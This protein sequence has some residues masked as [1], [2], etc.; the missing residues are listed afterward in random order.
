MTH[1][2]LRR[3][4]CVIIA[5]GLALLIS[6]Q[7]ESR[8]Q[9]SSTVPAS[10]DAA[11][12]LLV[13]NYF[14][15]LARNDID[16]FLKLWSHSAEGLEQR[17]QMMQRTSATQSTLRPIFSNFTIL[18]I[19]IE[20]NRAMLRIEAKR[21]LSA[22]A[23][24]SATQVSLVLECVKEDGEWRIKREASAL[25]EL[26]A[27][28]SKVKT[29]A[30]GKALLDEEKDLI[31]PVLQDLIL[32]QV[33]RAF[34]EQNHSQALLLGRIAKLIAEQRGDKKAVADAWSS[35]GIASYLT[36]KYPAALEAYQQNLKLE[37]E[38]GDQKQVASALINIGH[39]YLV[40][41]Q[42]NSALEYYQKGLSLREA[43]GEK[44]EIANAL[45]NVANAQYEQGHYNLAVE[46]YQKSIG[47][48][49]EAKDKLRIAVTQDRI[50][51]LLYDQGDYATALDY[52]QQALT[53]F[54]FL[55]EKQSTVRA[56]HNI[57]N[58]HYLQG[59]FGSALRFY[60]QSLKISEQTGYME[61]MSTTL[62]AVGLVRHLQGNLSQALEYY[63]RCLVV[64]DAL[65]DKP[66]VADVL[67][68]LGGIHLWLREYGPAL[69]Y[70]QRNRAVN[71]A[72]GDMSKM[73]W[74]LL[75]IGMV[76][77][78]QKDYEK[79]LS[80]Y[81]QSQSQFE[82]LKEAAGIASVL[83]RVSGIHYEQEK[84]DSALE[85][86]NKASAIANSPE[87]FW[88][89]RLRAGK[90]YH[91]LEQPT[92]ARQAFE[93]AIAT[94]ESQRIPPLGSK[95]EQ[96]RLGEDRIA[97]YLAMVDLLLSQ[98]QEREAFAYA[99]HAKM[100][101]LLAMLQ[102][103]RVQITKG[104]TA[105]EREREQKLKT[106]LSMLN[107]QI[108]REQQREKEPGAHAR[109]EALMVRGKQTQQNLLAFQARLFTLHPELK[110]LRGEGAAITLEQ[111]LSLIPDTK[112]ALVEYV[113]TDEG[114]YYF[115][116]SKE[117]R[118]RRAAGGQGSRT[119]AQGT[120]LLTPVLKV[121][122]LDLPTRYQVAGAATQF[123]Q[124]IAQKDGNFQQL[125]RDLYDLLLKPAQEQLA[126][127]TSLVIVPTGVLWQ[128]PFQALQ[129][130]ENHYLLEDQAVS[131]TP[132]LTALRAA[133][134]RRSR[135]NTRA[136]SA[137]TLVAFGNPTLGKDEIERVK[138]ALGEMPLGA[139][140][141]TEKEVEGIGQLYRA[142]R[143][144]VFI[145]AE[146]S[147]AQAKAEAGLSRVLHLAAHGVLNDAA[148]MYSHL[149]LAPADEVGKEDGLLEAWEMMQWDL[150]AEIAVMPVCT[151]PQTRAVPGSG[152]T[153]IMWAMLVAGCPTT[154][155]SQWKVTSESTTSLMVEF[156]RHLSAQTRPARGSVAKAQAWREAALKLMQD[157][158]FRHPFFWS[159]FW[160]VGDG[161]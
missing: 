141:E 103:G 62:F 134:Q 126:G 122:Q 54:Q 123:Q 155:T 79:A 24:Q 108:G 125:S 157:T 75:D 46:S 55:K 82:T 30:E 147:E 19:K 37:E 161:Y 40:Q 102:S 158:Q 14:E 153:G 32:G 67:T 42:H 118:N 115:V 41:G 85:L 11:L 128:L 26:A 23:T 148:P 3:C 49:D 96:R 65:D 8:G 47:L 94:I 21:T 48:R 9:T 90:A 44:G 71:E 92:P 145:G 89:A 77:G 76:Y 51:G 101:M 117:P 43:I 10:D 124:L 50:G 56:L 66:G 34:Y 160:V 91:K 152:V 121:Y 64:R 38:L 16:G 107:A 73:A 106:E 97:P 84:Y 58:I 12:R 70:F 150:Q 59:D 129:P 17:R 98:G 135:T 110:V 139:L 80:Y 144:K 15:T 53:K 52:Y 31:T 154:L 20:D 29:E 120:Q 60:D 22:Q 4:W 87:I 130:A 136:A 137:P 81:Q 143:R 116:L 132:S 72:L 39:V 99:E 111:A 138:S 88:H 27:A 25:G 93:E 83:L 133:R 159:G 156:H 68:N 104:M 1:A 36:K 13:A 113:E 7:N 109:L 6:T 112:T 100:R 69:E 2:K 146:A 105:Q 86:A 5:L 78:A 142:E 151:T 95:P 57:A 35:I 74:S 119:P 140:P 45:E 63:R 131:L 127:K 61:G 18:K 28:L 33:S 114:L 149:L